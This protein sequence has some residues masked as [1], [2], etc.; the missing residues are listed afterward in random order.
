M[1]LRAVLTVSFLCGLASAQTPVELKHAGEVH[2]LG[3]F[4]WVYEDSTAARSIVEIASK[5]ARAGF[6][7][8]E[9][10]V[11]NFNITASAIWCRFSLV[12]NS[13]ES[14][15]YLE[16]ANSNVNSVDLY[17]P[18]GKGNFRVIHGGLGS[19][20]DLKPMKT[21]RIIFPLTATR[22]DTV[23]GY[24]RFADVFPLQVNLLLGGS[25]VMLE[26]LEYQ[27]FLYGC[28]FGLML[29]LVAYNLFIFFSVKDNV[30]LYYILYILANGWFISLIT[31]YAANSPGFVRVIAQERPVLLP[32]LLGLTAT[33][34]SIVFLNLRN[35]SR[36]GY[37]FTLV[38][39]TLLQIVPVLE[40]AGMRHAAVMMI[41]LFGFI[42]SFVSIALGITV[43]RKGYK[44]AMIYLMAWSVY[45]TG[46]LIYIL[47]DLKVLPFNELTHNSLEIGSAIE[48]V[49][50]SM[51]V[52]DKIANFKKDK[53]LAQEE[54][55]LAAMENERLTREQ[56]IVLEQKV[57]E[58]THEL[59]EKN[60]EIID[61]INY[62]KRI[63]YALL[64]HENLLKENL[65]EYFVFF[66]P[67]DIV[68]G[69]FYWA[70]EKEGKF[71]LAVCDSTGHG[72]PGAFMSLLNISFLNE[73]IN[74][75]NIHDPAAVLD[76]VRARLIENIAQEGARDGMDA[77]LI[78]LDPANRKLTFASA[79][80]SLV[81]VSDGLLHTHTTDKMPVGKGERDDRFTSQTT[82]MPRGKTIYL[83]TDGFADQFGGPKGKKF[84]YKQL[85]ELL[86]AISGMDMQAQ[87]QKLE[88][89]F[90]NWREGFEQVDDVCI[91][92]LKV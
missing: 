13:G 43:W 26:R 60:R 74:E 37:R 54:A 75:K 19:N 45:L 70:T 24:I 36:R 73:G 21:H 65:P 29:M 31:G 51:A 32:Y 66:R 78:C 68:S 7:K 49:L 5:E 80:N 27:D 90:Q 72:V 56:N 71:Y 4:L 40:F 22:N 82:D 15:W 33:L 18:D 48:A 16:S 1:M 84:K 14:L 2:P 85:N 11:L 67:K 30:Y 6:R 86:V 42:F 92:G 10:Q 28:F 25:Q 58:R 62:A 91:I 50:L 89:A 53:E 76:H 59:A 64:A 8:S 39:F 12:N 17:L 44:P 41:Q 38:L 69:D 46:L 52:G 57:K 83:Y 87:K 55:L 77:I 61:S 35:Y 47:A 34:F 9:T 81:E 88:D 79:N 3:K 20:Q 23:T 63:Q